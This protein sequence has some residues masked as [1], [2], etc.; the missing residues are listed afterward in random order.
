ML[1]SW[2]NRYAGE[3]IALWNHE[4]VKDGYKELT[5]QSFRE[6]FFE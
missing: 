3:V 5:E 4:A 2:D 6:I 1:K